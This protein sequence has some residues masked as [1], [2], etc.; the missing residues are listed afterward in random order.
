MGAFDAVDGRERWRFRMGPA[1]PGRFGSADGPISTPLIAGGRVFALDNAGLLFALDLEPGRELWRV[2]LAV[3]LL[4]DAN[5]V[6][7]LD[8]QV[9]GDMDDPDF[10]ARGIVLKA[11]AN[12]ITKLATAPFKLLGKLV[13]GGSDLDLEAIEFEAG[14]ADLTPPER[15]KLSQIAAALNERPVLTLQVNG[16]FERGTDVPALQ[17]INVDNMVDALTGDLTDDA[18]LTR[19]VRKARE[20]LA[21]QQ[22]PE[23]DLRSLREEYSG[24]NPD[25]GERSFD[26]LAYSAAIQTQLEAAQ[27]VSEDLLQ[28][29]ARQRRDMALAYLESGQVLDPSRFTAGE[30]AEVDPDDSGRVRVPLAVEATTQAGGPD[31]A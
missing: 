13:P 21:Q 24:T 26:E 27:P 10:S 3:A 5:G 22:L 7:D 29:L 20:K 23:L 15:E 2:D 11:F 18:Q 30:L 16:G 9:S 8:L 19:K 28:T 17:K 1:F 12:L 25:T 14:R 4:T 31:G 6:I